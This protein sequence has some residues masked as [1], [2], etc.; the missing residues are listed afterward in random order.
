MTNPS[1][2]R[3]I[4]YYK[5]NISIIIIF[6]NSFTAIFRILSGL[7]IFIY[8]RILKLLKK[9]REF[10][11]QERLMLVENENQEI[12][13]NNEVEEN[14]NKENFKSLI[15][16]IKKYHENNNN[17]KKIKRRRSS[18]TE[19]SNEKNIDEWNNFRVNKNKYLINI[20]KIAN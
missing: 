17:L 9:R 6:L 7:G 20:I 10:E 8:L 13:N 4:N 5:Y 15:N 11:I 14:K 1:E 2:S 18:N 19:I 12:L 3:P 16:D